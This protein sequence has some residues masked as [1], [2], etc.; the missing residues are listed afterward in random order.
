MA[1][2]LRVM[3]RG[4][5]ELDCGEL[6]AARACAAHEQ[7]RCVTRPSGRPLA[8]LTACSAAR[9]ITGALHRAKAEAPEQFNA[10]AIMSRFRPAAGVAA[11]STWHS[12]SP[13]YRTLRVARRILP[14]RTDA[15]YC[16]LPV[17][18]SLARS[19]ENRH[20]QE[21]ALAFMRL[22]VAAAPMLEYTCVSVGREQYRLTP[23]VPRCSR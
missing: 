20:R 12:L 10:T 15:A 21:H 1:R 13:F 8:A 6:R 17:A 16:V 7:P 2:A 3:D 5:W 22:A 4:T 18:Y 9:H 23:A 14:T 19:F 11:G